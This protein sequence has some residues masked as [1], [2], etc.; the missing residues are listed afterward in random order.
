MSTA[1][2]NMACRRCRRVVTAGILWIANVVRDAVVPKCQDRNVSTQARPV[3]LLA[4][5]SVE[6][7]GLL[8]Q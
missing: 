2:Q 8:E 3:G 7:S 5:N 4:A 6:G 1:R